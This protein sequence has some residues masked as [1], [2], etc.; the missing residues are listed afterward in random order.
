MI[1]S[2][3]MTLL[4]REGTVFL[5]FLLQIALWGAESLLIQPFSCYHNN[6]SHLHATPNR[7]LLL[8]LK[9]S[10]SNQ[11][12]MSA[13]LSDHTK[14]Q[15]DDPS[16]VYQRPEVAGA[17]VNIREAIPMGKEQLD[18][19]IRIIRYFQS[20][21]GPSQWLD[22]GCGDGP[23]ADRLVK[24]FP[25]SY[26]TLID[27]SQPMLNLAK[28]KLGDNDHLEFRLADF[29]LGDFLDASTGNAEENEELANKF[30]VIVSG[31]AIHH[32]SHERKRSLYQQIF[33][34]LNPG[35]VFLSIEHIT[36]P[37][38]DLET[39]FE[40][41]FCDSMYDA[42][43]KNSNPKSRNEIETAVRN[44]LSVDEEANILAPVEDQ[45]DWLRQI[46]F[47]HVDCYFKFFILA[48][49]GGVKPIE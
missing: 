26:G 48:L 22:L 24:E 33:D 27:H 25:A 34:M 1:N 41:A 10:R 40:Y 20:A 6:L 16:L 2:R 9:L 42:Y 18:T 39:I 45:C 3:S 44:D 14:T 4:K 11:D 32:V 43:K 21:G 13:P 38:S 12:A 19:M 46:G 47:K 36:S 37:T 28:A 35:G 5:L 49:F 17:F 31:F 30:D 29:S 7:D 15:N 8:Q 23:L